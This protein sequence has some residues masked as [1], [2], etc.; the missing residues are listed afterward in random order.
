VHFGAKSKLFGAK[1]LLSGA[2]SRLCEAEST[3]SGSPANTKIRTTKS[4]ATDRTGPASFTC[5]DTVSVQPPR[6]ICA[7]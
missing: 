5:A 3:L 4:V 7:R 6:A 1:K 2:K